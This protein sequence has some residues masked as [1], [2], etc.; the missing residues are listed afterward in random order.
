MTYGADTPKD[1]GGPDGHAAPG[2]VRSGAW[3]VDSRRTPPADPVPPCRRRPPGRRHA[4]RRPSK[5]ARPATVNPARP[6]RRPHRRRLHA[7]AVPGGAVP[8]RPRRPRRCAPRPPGTNR[9]NTYR[10]VS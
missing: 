9:S 4:T 5:P 1:N 3:H 8:D 10:S 7:D 6:G 2:G